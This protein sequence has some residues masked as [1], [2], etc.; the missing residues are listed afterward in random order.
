MFTE[1]PGYIFSAEGAHL[2]RSVMREL[3]ALAA[4][5]GIISLAGGLPASEFLPLTQYQ[6]C[7]NAVLTRDG[8]RALQYSPQSTG[9][10]EWIADYMRGR[11]V[12]CTPE[13]I[14]ITNGNQQGLTI[15]SRMFLDPGDPAVIEETTFT[16]IQQVT[17]GRGADVLAIP[18]DLSSGAD[19]E[20]L[21]AAFAR[22]PHPRMA[23]LIPDFHNPLGV[24]ISREKRQRAAQL[25]P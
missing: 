5:P 11:G 20:A 8:G 21:E 25:A 23:V 3:L 14:F 6:E 4:D 7:L 12:D 15:L 1:K 13:Q 9:L 10:R 24:S 2:K 19:M 22:D 17:A 18:T 16:G